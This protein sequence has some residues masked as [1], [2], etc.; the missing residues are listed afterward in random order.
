M[1]ITRNDQRLIN[2]HSGEVKKPE[3]VLELGEIA[4][5]H[6]AGAGTQRIY[7][8]TASGSARD[9]NTLVE[10]VPKAYIEGLNTFMGTRV[11][12][13]E[14]IVG[15]E[16]ENETAATGLVKK[17]A[18]NA[19]AITKLNGDATTDG[20]VAKA[21]ADAKSALLGDAAEDYNTLG[22]LEDKIIAAEAAAKGAATVVTKNSNASHLTL[23]VTTDEITGAKT[24]E[25]GESDIASATLLGTID[26]ASTASTAFGKIAANTAAITK[27]NGSGEGSVAKAVADAK[28]AIEGEL[29]DGDA[30]TLKALNTKIDTLSANAK[31]YEMKKLTEDEVSALNNVNVKEAYKLVDEDE[32]QVGD[33]ILIY[34]DSSL[35]EVKLEEQELKFTYILANGSESTVGVDVSTFLAESE[36]KNGLQVNDSGEVSVKVDAT[37]EEFLSVGGDGIKLSGVQTA[38]D[39]AVAVETTRAK[40]AEETNAAAIDT[41]NGDAST[42]GSVAK[43]VADAKSELTTEIDKKVDKVAGSRLMT[44]AEGTKLESIAEGAQVNVLEGVQLNGIDLTV[45]DKKV[46]VTALQSV[47]IAKDK[48]SGAAVTTENNVATF[49]FS[50]LVID[51]GTY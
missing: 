14:T 30:E 3:G 50:A 38:I 40:T 35:K 31:S 12:A 36:F 20:S 6:S 34:K 51:C 44:D 25:I 2:L 19:A 7:I 45:T 8:E 11:S 49:D 9:E 22:K 17:V 18:D 28:A 13:L 4:V 32:T 1:A 42:N 10:F 27:L 41:L 37:S 46:N 43:A 23:E 5:Q 29:E 33:T 24:Y 39:D 21:V 47:V 48:A 16:A 15:K 26:D